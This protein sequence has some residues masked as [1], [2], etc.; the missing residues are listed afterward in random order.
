MLIINGVMFFFVIYHALYRLKNN[1]VDAI[2]NQFFI[3]NIFFALY[4]ILPALFF[5]QINTIFNWGIKESEYNISTLL[6]GYY[7][8]VFQICYFLSKDK[9]ITVSKYSTKISKNS[10]LFLNICY[11]LFVLYGL[12]ILIF[13]G[14]DIASTIYTENNYDGDQPLSLYKIKNI[15]YVMIFIVPML[16]SFNQN[17]KYFILPFILILLDFCQ[18]TRTIA[19]ISFLTIYLSC[20]YF[21]R[22]IYFN[23]VLMFLFFMIVV[24]IISRYTF[25]KELSIPWYITALGEFRETYIALP[26]K[27]RIQK[28]LLFHQ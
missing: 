8:I 24:G 14:V 9:K 1:G 5:E 10:I 22:K 28:P 3:L 11:W 18:G 23:L 6:V 17:V 20:A 12:Y 26:Y 21:N 4:L 27:V 7:F 25:I 13:K 2:Y 16:Y 15:A 19:L